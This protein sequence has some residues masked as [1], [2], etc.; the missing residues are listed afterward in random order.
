MYVLWNRG[1][2]TCGR[3]DV[4]VIHLSDNEGN[5]TSSSCSGRPSPRVAV[6]VDLHLEYPGPP[7]VCD[8]A[9]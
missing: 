1:S 8:L 9:L 5:F 6:V 3:G 2:S 4:S 7:V